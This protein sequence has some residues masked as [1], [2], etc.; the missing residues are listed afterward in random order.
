MP[1]ADH[2]AGSQLQ[3]NDHFYDVSRTLDLLL[4][5]VSAANVLSAD[6]VR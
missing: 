1:S 6:F 5:G 4:T 2:G 3:N